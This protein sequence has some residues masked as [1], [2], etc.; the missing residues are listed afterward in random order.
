MVVA[1]SC[2]VTRY[3]KGSK[4]FHLGL[5]AASPEI[6]RMNAELPRMVAIL[7][8]A[9]KPEWEVWMATGIAGRLVTRRR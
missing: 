6:P 2:G 7:W 4:S 8:M 5:R 3:H 9:R 1:P